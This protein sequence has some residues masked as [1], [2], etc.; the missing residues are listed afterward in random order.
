[1]LLKTISNTQKMKQYLLINILALI[2]FISFGQSQESPKG[3][4]FAINSNIDGELYPVRVVPSALYYKG[5]NQFE[6]GVGF[7]PINR[8]TQKL[9]SGEI[10]YKRFPNGFDQKFNLYFVSRISYVKRAIQ[11]YF[12]T[13]Y[14]YLFVHGGYGFEINPFKNSFISTNVCIGAFTYNK[15]SKIPY[16]AFKRQ[17]LF[18]EIDLNLAFQFN[19]GYRL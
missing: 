9:V 17:E 15:S 10:N 4:G 18:D 11:N 7:N 14:N 1:M 12:P 3:I 13:S 16:D 19:I 5:K 6:L 8:T 2:P